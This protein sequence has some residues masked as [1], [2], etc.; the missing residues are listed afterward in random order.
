MSD[1]MKFAAKAAAFAVAFIIMCWTLSNIDS[2]ILQGYSLVLTVVTFG[3]L[4][5]HPEYER[6][7]IG[8]DHWE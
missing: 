6:M 5:R 7:I 1:G 4:V 3:W 8:K 2:V